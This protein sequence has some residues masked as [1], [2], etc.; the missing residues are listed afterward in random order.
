MNI[1]IKFNNITKNIEITENE[2]YF[3]I[4]KKIEKKFRSY[5]DNSGLNKK[6]YSIIFKNKVINENNEILL[7][8][9]RNNDLIFVAMKLKGGLETIINLLLTADQFFEKIL[10]L[11]LEL[12]RIFGLVFETIPLIFEPSKLIDDIISGIING[13]TAGIRGVIDSFSFGREKNADEASEKERLGVFGVSDKSKAICAPASFID[14]IILV[15]CPPLALFMKRK[16][17]FFFQVL[18]CCLLTYKLYYFP[19]FIFAAV[20]ILC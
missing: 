6:K 2:N 7:E 3:S 12:I 16:M 5:F 14:L 20:Y 19:G 18:L 17:K 13:V 11:V 1:I 15:L 4:C 10:K 8:N 9:L